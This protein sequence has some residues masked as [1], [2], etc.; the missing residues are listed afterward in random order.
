MTLHLDKL[1]RHELLLK[2]LIKTQTLLNETIE[3][4]YMLCVGDLRSS[5]YIYFTNHSNSR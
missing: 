3:T 2:L 4:H 1:I 5:I